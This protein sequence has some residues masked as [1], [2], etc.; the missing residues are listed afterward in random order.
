MARGRDTLTVHGQLLVLD[1]YAVDGVVWGWGSVWLDADQR[2]AGFTTAGG[3]GLTFEAVRTDLDDQLLRLRAIA[4]R[5]RLSEL[6][7]ASRTV[8]PVATGKLALVGATLITGT[9]NAAVPNATIVIDG[10]R[11]IAAGPSAAV[12]APRDARR[13]DLRGKTIA[14]GLWDMHAHLMQWEWAPV[15]LAAGVTTVR[16]MGNVKEF[17]VPFRAAVDSGKGLGPHMVLAGLIDGGGPNAF[18]AINASTPEQGR[19][20]V[21]MYHALGFQQMKLYSL[22]TPAVVSAICDEAHRLG[23]TVTGHIPY[24]LTLLAA[25]DSGM[26]H[27]AHLAIRGDAGSD[28]V[29]MVID[30]LKAHHTIMDPTASWGELG[31]H[32]TAIPVASFQPGVNRVPP[33]LAQRINAMGAAIDTATW[34][35]RFTRALRIIGQLRQAGVPVVPGTDEGL[36]GYSVYRELELYVQAGF[37]PNEA[38]QSATVVSARAMGLQGSRGTLE[39]GKEADLIV[40]DGNP[41]DDIA[42]LRTV[43]M[44]MK[45]GV[46][47]RSA[48]I[49]KAIGF[50]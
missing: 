7:A 14:P 8:Q 41:I 50:K 33:V 46:L 2:L 10:G 31:G 27:V 44:V 20:A 1:R 43:T 25:V 35:Q 13:I 18:G 45:D 5:D 11:V 32:S 3:G 36:P 23:M 47:Y 28:S 37:T 49:W 21:R 48:D 16:D 26:D 15:Y 22:L 29:R 24:A 34:R 38:I 9:D 6:S 42:N 40:L 4:T 12:A 17:I 30:S 19:S 39:P